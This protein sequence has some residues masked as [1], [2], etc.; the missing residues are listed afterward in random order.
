MCSLLNEDDLG[1]PAGVTSAKRSLR[2]RTGTLVS[3]GRE[4][5]FVISYLTQAQFWL[6]GAFGRRQARQFSSVLTRPAFVEGKHVC[7][8]AH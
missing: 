2:D 3:L 4:L 7:H 5:S 8:P 6:A 1:G